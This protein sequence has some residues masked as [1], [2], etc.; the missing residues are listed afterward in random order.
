MTSWFSQ[1]GA[2]LVALGRYFLNGNTYIILVFHISAFLQDIYFNILK[3]YYFLDI[4]IF[5]QESIF[6]SQLRNES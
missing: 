6:T 2:Y 1:G 3:S 5:H 4:C